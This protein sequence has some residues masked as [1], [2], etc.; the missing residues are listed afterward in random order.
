M[1][2]PLLRAAVVQA[3]VTPSLAEGL[4][5]TAAL[6]REARA[7]GATLIVFPETWLPGYPVWLDVCRDAA[8]WNHAPV[9]AVFRRLAEDG[10]AVPGAAANRLSEI[11]R[12]VDATLV[13][14][15]SERVDEGPGQGT[16]YNSILT[17]GADG[18]LVNHHRKLIP[19]YTER[20]VWGTG[21]TAGLRSVMILARA[22]PRM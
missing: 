18:R 16:L 8:L 19:T 6:A 20:M 2:T 14:G 7:Q 22:P 12:D 11:A 3:E 9:K 1:T 17:F 15:V 10:V 4:E 5:R 13:V 21:D